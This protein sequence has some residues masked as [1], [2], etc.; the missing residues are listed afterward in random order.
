[1]LVTSDLFILSDEAISLLLK[2]ASLLSR[3]WTCNQSQHFH[4]SPA[5]AIWNSTLRRRIKRWIKSGGALAISPPVS[6]TPAETAAW[7]PHMATSL[8]ARAWGWAG[9]AQP[10]TFPF[11]VL[12]GKC[13]A[14]RNNT[15]Q[16]SVK[17]CGRLSSFK[18]YNTDFC[19]HVPPF[20]LSLLKEEAEPLWDWSA[21]FK[22]N[23]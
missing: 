12:S 18:M 7:L 14:A 3:D 23:K 6:Q 19:Y 22:K 1:M 21:V 8:P 4:H 9:C 20:W 5:A 15:T 10:L 17:T 16:P 2:K 11:Y 13:P